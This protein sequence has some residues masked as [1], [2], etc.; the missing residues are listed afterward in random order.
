MKYRIFAFSVMVIILTSLATAQSIIEQAKEFLPDFAIENFGNI[1]LIFGGIIL[2]LVLIG[3]GTYFLIMH[4]KFNIE[5]ILLEDVSGS[6]NLEPVGRD[7][8]MLVK[9]GNVGTELLYLK[10]RKVYRGAYGKR[11]GKRRYYFALGKDGYWYNVT[12]G[13]LDEGMKTI[14]IKPTSINMRYQNEAL[15]E[16][17]KGRYDKKSWWTQYGQFVVNIA[18]FAVVVLMFWLYFSSFKEAAPAMTE[19]AKALK[20]A[21]EAIRQ[22][23]GGLDAIRA[24]G[25]IIPAS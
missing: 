1:L 18:F 16:I 7:K 12:F 4:L 24:G 20:D 23:V 14:N 3:I 21:S 6:D 11:M 15:S 19:A 17:I 25:G 13:S 5:I 2:L 10:K 22:A 9:V 8:A